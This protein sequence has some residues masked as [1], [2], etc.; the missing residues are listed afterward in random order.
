MCYNNQYLIRA[1][2]ICPLIRRA[3]FNM[4]THSVMKMRWRSE[5][6][7]SFTLQKGAK[8]GGCSSPMLFT[9]YFDGLL[10]RL[11][12]KGIGYFIGRRYCGVF[13]YADDLALDRYLPQYSVLKKLLK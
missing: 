3:L 9:V 12:A 4:Y 1:Q 10:R 6:S 2:G 8:Q 5:T 11:E 13:G 7:N